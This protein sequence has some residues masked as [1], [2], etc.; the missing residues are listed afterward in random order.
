[1]A[2]RP[3]AEEFGVGESEFTLHES[4]MVGETD[5]GELGGKFFHIEKFLIEN[6]FTSNMN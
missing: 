2:S 5:D 6:Y 1:M 3:T 4:L